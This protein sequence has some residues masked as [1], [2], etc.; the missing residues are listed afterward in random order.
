MMSPVITRA[1]KQ[2]QQPGALVHV[3]EKKVDFTEISIME[4][5]R[6]HDFREWQTDDVAELAEILQTDDVNW[7]NVIGLHQVEIVEQVGHVFGVHDLLIEDILNTDQ[8]P[9]SERYDNYI[10]LVFKILYLDEENEKLKTDQISIVFGD[11]FVLTFQEQKSALFEPLRRRIRQNQGR[12]HQAGA[13]YLAYAVADIVVDQYFLIA[14]YLSNT[15]EA[16]EDELVEEPT[17]ETLQTILRLN[18]NL[19]S[20]QKALWPLRQIFSELQHI[21]SNFVDKS[22]HIY[23]RDIYDHVLHNIDTL[24]TLRNIAAGMLDIYLS[25]SSNKMNEVM[26]LLTVMSTIFIPLTF[27]TSVYGMNFNYMPELAW[28]WGYPLL[29][30][31][32]IVIAG[33]MLVYFK[34]KGWL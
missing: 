10:Y 31:V 3:G 2:G 23:F 28:R 18:R 15:I 29:W 20:A 4:Y 34:R 8:R 17:R 1:V 11:T 24:E 9:K 22:N 16:V 7:V 6:G 27:F 12:I 26:Q 13:D 19:L 32:N 30:V 14:E 21:E 5:N 25:S 33:S